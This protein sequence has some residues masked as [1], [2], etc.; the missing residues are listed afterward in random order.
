MRGGLVMGNNGAPVDSLG[1]G[2][3]SGLGVEDEPLTGAQLGEL[4]NLEQ[5]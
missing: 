3:D 5:Q 1:I 4:E 2:T